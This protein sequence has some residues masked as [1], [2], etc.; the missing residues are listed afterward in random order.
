ME[1]TIAYFWAFKA[2]LL[3]VMG[4]S[5]YKWIY[6]HKFQS[7]LY[8][9]IFGVFFVFGII[10]PIKLATTN[11]TTTSNK[12]IE[13]SKTLLNKVEDNSFKE[14]VDSVQPISHDTIWSK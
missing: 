10:S 14:R 3:V 9:V 13:M 1:V 11:Y 8:G 7:K 4:F 12:A 2:L 6:V 5:A